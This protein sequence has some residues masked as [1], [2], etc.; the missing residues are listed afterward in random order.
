MHR[1]TPTVASTMP[2]RDFIVP[3]NS[4]L[5]NLGSNRSSSHDGSHG[6]FI[7]CRS[8]SSPPSSNVILSHEEDNACDRVNRMAACEG[9]VLLPKVVPLSPP[10]GH[11]TTNAAGNSITPIP[12]STSSNSCGF[13]YVFP[14]NICLAAS[15][16]SAASS[17]QEH[18]AVCQAEE[19]LSSTDD[20]AGSAD[21]I[22]MDYDEELAECSQYIFS[23]GPY[24][25]AASRIVPYSGYLEDSRSA[26]EDDHEEE[27]TSEN[28]GCS[29]G[30][31]PTQHPLH[32]TP[33]WVTH[34]K[35]AMQWYHACRHQQWLQS[36]PEAASLTAINELHALRALINEACVRDMTRLKQVDAETFAAASPQ[37]T[38][39]IRSLGGLSV[40]CSASPAEHKAAAL[41]ATRRQWRQLASSVQQDEVA[42]DPTL[43]RL[44]SANV[45][46]FSLFSVPEGPQSVTAN[47][48]LQDRNK[49]QRQQRQERLLASLKAEG[50]L[51]TLPP[52]RAYEEEPPV[53][54]MST[55]LPSVRRW[56]LASL[57]MPLW[58][59]YSTYDE[60]QVEPSHLKEMSP[61]E[62]DSPTQNTR[63][64]YS[65]SST[66]VEGDDG[67]DMAALVW[68]SEQGLLSLVLD[69]PW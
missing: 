30:S 40:P 10:L 4:E 5:L 19:N 23:S 38:S 1:H 20:A 69:T 49:R 65:Q 63:S 45:H 55:P 34:Q 6:S 66:L 17:S 31:C 54:V 18:D 9:K 25:P 21:Y 42:N 50:R 46:S 62:E 52:L 8:C 67:D 14:H 59:A 12:T 13:S 26:T 7:T 53:S 29:F 27:T 37:I 35:L 3:E 28:E 51:F 48:A 33:A 64:S 2:Q 60:G 41:A 68:A 39:D 32:F 44:L 24:C 16:V 47:I 11:Y 15:E 56:G 22:P 61:F 36:M 43:L 57:D 58:S